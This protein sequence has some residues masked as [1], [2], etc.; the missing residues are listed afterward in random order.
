MEQ[1][2]PDKFT[3]IVEVPD[4]LT[5]EIAG[6]VPHVLLELIVKLLVVALT[7]FENVSEILLG[8]EVKNRVSVAGFELEKVG[9]VLSTVIRR[10]SG[11]T[12]DK[13]PTASLTVAALTCRVIVPFPVHPLREIVAP[14]GKMDPTVTVQLGD[15]VATVVVTPPPVLVSGVPVSTVPPALD[16]AKVTAMVESS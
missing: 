13:L 10:L 3:V 14:V 9:T 2:P 6:K 1:A 4:P 11:E 8:K 5:L 12:V 16:G 7:L 15:P